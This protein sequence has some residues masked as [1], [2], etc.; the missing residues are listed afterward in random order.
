MNIGIDFGITNTD[1]VIENNGTLTFHTFASENNI[2]TK[3]LDTIFSKLNLTNLEIENIAVTGGKSSNLPESYN[4]IAITKVN[5][6]FAIGSGAKEIYNIK[7]D[8][9]VVV[10]TGT[11]TACVSY[12]NGEFHHLGGISFG[13][14]TLQGLSN[15]LVDTKDSKKIDSMAF[16][17]DKNTLDILIGEVVNDIGSLDPDITA[18]NFSKA[19]DLKKFTHEDI[20][21]SLMNM[22]GEVIGTIAYLNALLIGVNKVYFVGRVSLLKS[23]T[24]AIDKR[25]ELAGVTAAYIKNREFANAIGSLSFLKIDK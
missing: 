9:F 14:G 2:D 3:L 24:S 13:G 7:E 20:A 10:S 6:V 25:L 18:S 21:A 1:L 17:G 11:G 4:S 22:T 5:E 15:L 12:I 8:S 19:R 23:V 16:D